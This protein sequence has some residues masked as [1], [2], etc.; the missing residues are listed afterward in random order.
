MERIVLDHITPCAGDGG[1]FPRPQNVPT[2][3]ERRTPSC[4]CAC[5][6]SLAVARPKAVYTHCPHH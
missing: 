1:A 2:A 4:C 6:G 5:G 3:G